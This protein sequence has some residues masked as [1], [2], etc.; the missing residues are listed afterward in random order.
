RPFAEQHMVADLNVHRD[1]LAGFIASAGAN[2]DDFAL[3]WLLLGGVGDDDAP[4]SFLFGID[5][6]DDNAVVERAKFHD[7]PPNQLHIFRCDELWGDN[8]AR[9][10]RCLAPLPRES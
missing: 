9:A 1:Q 3:L 2:G 7:L 4:G 8:T 6:L 10:D 5:T